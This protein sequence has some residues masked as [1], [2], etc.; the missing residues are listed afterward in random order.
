METN[1]GMGNLEK[2]KA[3][4]LLS[5]T[6]LMMLGLSNV[7]KSLMGPNR[8]VTW[9]DGSLIKGRRPDQTISAVIRGSSPCNMVTI[10]YV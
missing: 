2:Y 10:L 3:F 7:F 9:R 8:L 5:W 4:M 6:T 1:E